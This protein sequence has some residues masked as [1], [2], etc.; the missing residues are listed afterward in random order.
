[1]GALM[2]MTS[3]GKCLMV[4][5]S[6]GTLLGGAELSLIQM[7]VG[8]RY[9]GLDV[10]VAL[11]NLDNKKYNEMILHTGSSLIQMPTGPRI[12][13]GVVD[14]EII[15]MYFRLIRQEDYEFVITNTIVPFA[16]LLAAKSAGVTTITFLREDLWNNEILRFT[17]SNTFSLTK[18]LL[19][20]SD[21]IIC[22][23]NYTLTQLPESSNTFHLPNLPNQIEGLLELERSKNLNGTLKVSM[24]GEI[25]SNKGF[26]ELLTLAKS[27]EEFDI[28]FQLIGSPRFDFD[29]S[30]LENLPQN[31]KYLGYLSDPRELYASTDVLISLSKNESFGRTILESMAAMVPVVSWDQGGRSELI[32]NGVTGFKHKIGNITSFADSLKFLAANTGHRLKMGEAAREY[33]GQNWSQEIY[34]TSLEEIFLEITN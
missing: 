17:H 1:M 16:P 32:M 23:S 4:A 12:V 31:I 11:P 33:F 21:F 24:V 18:S 34:R 5:H 6:S 7:I 10:T 14:S 22:N 8:L 9:I 2:R 25:S 13:V 26:Y 27:L 29:L 15:D 19:L 28:S 30:L 20:N 3:L